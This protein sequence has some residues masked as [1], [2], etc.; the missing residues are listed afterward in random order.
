[1]KAS[2]LPR[3][4]KRSEVQWTLV[5]ILAA[6]GLSF[7]PG[8]NVLSFYFCLPMA[9]LL[10]M[11]AGSV[12]ITATFD[13][14][15]RG[16]STGA[17]MLRGMIHAVLLPVG[18]LTVISFAHFLNGP[19]DYL[20][21]LGH[22]MAGPWASA[23]TG[24]A[25]AAACSLA[26]RRERNASAAFIVIFVL[27]FVPNAL[28]LYLEPSVRF[29]NP[30]L[31]LY[32]GP[33]YDE[34]IEVTPDYIAFR[35][36][37]LAAAAALIQIVITV[38]G[39]IDSGLGLRG[40][41]PIDA[42]AAMLL[43]AASGVLWNGS[44]R[45]DFT[46]GRKSIEAELS[47]TKASPWCVIHADSG[48]ETRQAEL[49]RLIDDCG[50][51]HRQMAD[52]FGVDS[53]VPIEVYLYRDTDQKARLIGARWVEISK[54]WLNEVHVTN[55]KPGDMILGHEIAHVAAG[56]LAGN[57]LAMPL[58]AGLLPDMG[59]VE[60]LA[61]AAA[62]ADEGPSPHE[63]AAGMLAADIDPDVESLFSPLSF[64]TGG[65][66]ASYN[67]AGSFLRFIHDEKG[68]EAIRRIAAGAPFT[69]AAGADLETLVKEWRVYL[70]TKYST[71]GREALK[72]RAAARFRDPGVLNR[73][74]PLDVSRKLR[75]A[76]VALDGLDGAAAAR[77]LHEAS[78]ID[79]GDRELAILALRAA[80]LAGAADES[81]VIDMVN[82][83][84]ESRS[85]PPGTGELAAAADL[86]ALKALSA[87][88]A[89]GSFAMRDRAATLQSELLERLS[90]GDSR[91][92]TCIRALALQ[93]PSEVGLAIFETLADPRPFG[94]RDVSRLADLAK[95][96]PDVA[97]IQ[98]FCARAAMLNGSWDQAL[99][100]LD[101]FAA[102][103]PSDACTNELASA[104]VRMAAVATFWSGDLVRAAQALDDAISLAGFEGD[105]L[106]LEEYRERIA[107]TARHPR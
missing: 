82:E 77:Y 84:L 42:T 75:D 73:R 89:P 66:A 56:R 107:D 28:T 100:C 48:W 4:L 1:M 2:E 8:F 35:L 41:R 72:A 74:C 93:A 18:P 63:W 39:M 78:C 106:R 26:L 46:K 65:A 44:G 43:L 103:H 81:S 33:I 51:R 53:T 14:R 52:F 69:E 57:W 20:F 37:C 50:F 25:T 80:I 31:G 90:D 62:F 76:I 12:V 95:R 10:A 97:V 91:R 58:T 27:S 61:V 7:V 96:M 54:P 104:S 64:I 11:A 55:V 32:P 85:G 6:I 87:P 36:W 102:H 79:P 29:F 68:T 101:R 92:A 17:G 30:F 86:L 70:E 40:I 98:Y 71:I 24:G 83:L 45:F 3:H 22:Y 38:R 19:C 60:G 88:N 21:G 94:E 47:V 67:T 23:V 105:R 49:D 59:R 34:L 5:P 16:L 9:L 99:T 15:R 13:A